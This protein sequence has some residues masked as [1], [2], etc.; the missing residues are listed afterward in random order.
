[1]TSTASSRWGSNEDSDY[2]H[3]GH[4]GVCHTCRDHE[5]SDLMKKYLLSAVIVGLFV[6]FIVAVVLWVE[7]W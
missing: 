3:L 1:M 2:S 5:C 4:H 7:V 6:G